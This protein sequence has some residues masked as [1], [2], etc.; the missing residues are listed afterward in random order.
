MAKNIA[1][2]ER[3]AIPAASW[4]TV[5]RIIRAYG[6]ATVDDPSAEEIA[7]LGGLQRTVI[8]GCNKF[9]R[10]AGIVHPEKNKL[11]E[12][13][14]Q[15]ATGWSI[16]N[17]PMATDALQRI[18]TATPP[19]AQLVNTIRARGTMDPQLFK[20]QII[21]AAG[22]D[23]K[24]FM[25]QFVKT[26]MDMLADSGLVQIFDDGVSP[27]RFNMSTQPA[28]TLSD[29]SN[30]GRDKRSRRQHSDTVEST[31][32]SER[33]RTPIPFGAD[34]LGY[35]ELPNDWDQ[36]ELPRLLKMIELIFSPDS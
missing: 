28:E 20:G 2:N 7:A 5:K 33:T 13:G 26:I 4:A 9:L 24:S 17:E 15:L 10:S 30:E 34:R 11:T 36:K 35:L 23:S 27:G 14:N 3:L 18:I 16:N 22:L 6:A 1:E 31:E 25:L 21:M 29:T 32:R 19:L 8:S 12:I